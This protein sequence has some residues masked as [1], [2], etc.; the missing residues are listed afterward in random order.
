VSA[1]NPGF[2]P[3][4]VTMLR[5]GSCPLEILLIS[6][7]MSLVPVYRF[8]SSHFVISSGHSSVACLLDLQ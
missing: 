1:S 5:F 8:L 4:R 6:E 3:P 7:L 2:S